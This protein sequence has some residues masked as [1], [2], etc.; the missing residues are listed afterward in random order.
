M[1]KFTV[2]LLQLNAWVAVLIGS[3]IVLDPVSMLSAHGLQSDLSAG[4]M[5]ELRAPGG[6]LI[7]AGLLIAYCSLHDNSLEQGLFIAM[8]VYGGYGS[9]RL[10]GFLVDGLPPMEILIATTIELVLFGLSLVT[11]I[12]LR[13]HPLAQTA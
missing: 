12:Q 7:A 1:K 10:I 3:F 8:L 4:L 5:S 13:N 6:L 2:T 9:A 11:M